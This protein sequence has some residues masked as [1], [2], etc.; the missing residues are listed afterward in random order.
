MPPAHFIYIG[1]GRMKGRNILTIRHM[2]S[3]S[4]DARRLLL[5]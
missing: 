3:F 2:Q 4:R 1:L 5:A